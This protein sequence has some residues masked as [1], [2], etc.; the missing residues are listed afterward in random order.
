MDTYLCSSMGEAITVACG[1]DLFE[2]RL[3]TFVLRDRD[4]LVERDNRGRAYCAQRIV[5]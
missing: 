3:G 2:S 5:K 1:T 4:R